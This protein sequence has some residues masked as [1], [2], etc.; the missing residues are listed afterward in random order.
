MGWDND[1]IIVKDNQPL[2]GIRNTMREIK[3]A[4]HS[5]A[6][7][8]LVV[9]LTYR[10]KGGSMIDSESNNY[11]EY[12]LWEPFV[13]VGVLNRA[14]WHEND[15]KGFFQGMFFNNLNRQIRTGHIGKQELLT[16]TPLWKCSKKSY[17]LVMAGFPISQF[18]VKHFRKWLKSKDGITSITSITSF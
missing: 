10:N 16:P 14:F 5:C 2:E 4:D 12:E 17:A 6:N 1:D 18:L 9:V 8:V 11:N 15:T 13:V 3:D 7:C